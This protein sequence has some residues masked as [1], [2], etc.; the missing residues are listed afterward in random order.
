MKIGF[1]G[2]GIMGKPMALNIAKKHDDKVFVYDHHQ[3]N[4]DAL[5]AAGAVACADE[6]EV[7]KQV[8]TV[9]TMVPRSENT[10]D[11]YTLMLPY[12]KEGMACI[13]MSTIDPAV[14][15]EVSEMVKKTG[16]RFV[17]APV[18][19]SKAA[20]EAGELGIYVGGTDDDYEYVKPILDYMGN[21]VMHLGGNG[22]GL[23]M[24]VL[25]N[26]LVGQ[27][28]NG[29]NETMNLGERYGISPETFAQ[30]IAIGGAQNSYLNNKAAVIAS[31]DW[32]PAFSVK[33][34]HKDAH[35]F[36]NMA[37]DKGFHA[38]GA[39]NV[40]RV[41]DEAMEAG[42]AANDFSETYEIVGR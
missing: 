14:S 29:V 6:V 23:V 34:M 27:I 9:I 12:L 42:F 16:A 5:V 39:E 8:D 11:A 15:V 3:E 18:V 24:K 22:S 4:I 37:A 30:A 1:I 35:F 20:A 21:N 17:D 25:H 28:Q 33:N 38:P 13:D 26:G 41:Y 2:L 10:R 31:K 7:I 19:K 32:S 40:V 36:L